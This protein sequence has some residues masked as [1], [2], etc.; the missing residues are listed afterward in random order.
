MNRLATFETPEVLADRM[1]DLSAITVFDR[2]LDPSAGRG[3]LIAKLP[4]EQQITAIE[5]DPTRAAHLAMMPHCREGA[6]SVSQTD[7]LDY[8]G[9]GPGYFGTFFNA[10]LMTPPC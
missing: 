3:R 9:K 5:I 2:V 7:F 8:V 4:R 10:I 1:R 6:M